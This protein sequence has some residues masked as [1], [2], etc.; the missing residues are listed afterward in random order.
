MHPGRNRGHTSTV[1]D[2]MGSHQGPIRTIAK[3]KEA[4]EAAPA[5]PNA[6]AVKEAIERLEERAKAEAAA[7]KLKAEVAGAPPGRSA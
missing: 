6:P 3:L 2:Y 5:S 7:L 4:L 1:A